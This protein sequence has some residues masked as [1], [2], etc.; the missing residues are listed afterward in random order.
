MAKYKPEDR[1]PPTPKAPKPWDAPP[2][3]FESGDSSTA[4][5]YESVGRALSKWELFEGE[6]A[7]LFAA[8]VGAHP[9][10][11]PAVRAYGSVQ[12]FRG[13]ADMVESAAEA[14]FILYPNPEVEK[15][16]TAVMVMARGFADR[17]NEVAHG[18]VRE[19]VW[20]DGKRG[21]GLFP[22]TYST[23][24]NR[25]VI[26][27]ELILRVPMPKYAYTSEEINRFNQGFHSLYLDITRV[28]WDVAE[29]REI[30]TKRAEA[31]KP[32]P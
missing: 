26:P 7:D 5:T 17:R 6:M 22:A 1:P 29:H 28:H 24:K 2:L 16:L 13:R 20:D 12:S 19:P 25:M 21:A 10:S 14:F 30:A 27:G 31:Q 32:K 4:I 8:L 23:T 18:V 15:Q 11:L 3:R 9:D